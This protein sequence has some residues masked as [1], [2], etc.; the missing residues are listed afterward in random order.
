[1]HTATGAVKSNRNN[2]SISKDISNPFPQ[3]DCLRIDLQVYDA[4]VGASNGLI[5]AMPD[6]FLPGHKLIQLLKNRGCTA[7]TVTNK[8]NIA[9]CEELKA[10][11][12]DILAGAEFDC[13]EPQTGADVTVLAYGFSAGQLKE[14]V[15][16]KA[17]VFAFAK[18]AFVENIPLVWA[19]PNPSDADF[20]KLCLIFQNILVLSD[21][22]NESLCAEVNAA[23]KELTPTKLKTLAKQ[24]G[25]NP[26]DY[27]KAPWTRGLVGGSGSANGLFAGRTG[28]LLYVPRL[29]ERLKETSA[30]SLAVEALL[31]GNGA[32]FGSAGSQGKAL[33]DGLIKATEQALHIRDEY[34]PEIFLQN[35]SAG[36]K[37]FSL[38]AAN[39]LI[40]AKQ[41]PFVKAGLKFFLA[42]VK[43][44]SPSLLFK[45]AP[46]PAAYKGIWSNLGQINSLMKKQAEPDIVCKHIDAIYAETLQL[47]A[48]EAAAGLNKIDGAAAWHIIASGD[49]SAASVEQTAGAASADMS[50][51]AKK[52]AA[53]AAGTAVLN[54]AYFLA[55]RKM[56]LQSPPRQKRMLWLTDTLE[57]GNG[58]AMFLQSMLTEIRRRNLPIDIMVCSNKLRSGS[59]LKV[60]KPEAGFT[61]PFYPQQPFRIPSYVKIQQ[62]FEQ[63]GYDRIIASTEGPMG[64]A[65]LYLKHAFRVPAHFYMHTDW[66]AFG[67][68]ML[69]FSKQKLTRWEAWL[70]DIYKAFDK[71]FV[72]NSD[73]KKWLTGERM[74]FAP[75]NVYQSAHWADDVF[76]PVKASKQKLFGVDG[77]TPLLLFV[78]RLSEE[79]GIYDLPDIL[80][81]VKKRVPNAVLAIA[82]AGPEDAKIKAALP[83]AIFL[84]WT[85][86]E[87]LPAYYSSADILLLPSRFD[88]FGVVV[89]EALSCGCPVAAYNMKGPKDILT[90]GKNGFLANTKA[91][92]A[93]DITGYLLAK[94]LH[95]KIKKAAIDRAKEYTAEII[96]DKLIKDVNL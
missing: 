20:H 80:A 14:L 24:Y 62:L 34:I 15:R 17:D 78:G 64:I 45:L 5:A 69:K 61:L 55:A 27:C 53:P 11:G 6:S 82:G 18:Y 10:A 12:I 94:S 90:H 67:R 42:S 41:K 19:N 91:G 92:M 2:K 87:K 29:S 56:S 44:Q 23:V 25:I 74:E 40:K 39:L 54:A 71:L 95:N 70:I 31:A 50:K 38:A 52:I 65:A 46:T 47:L 73:Q 72:L 30:S 37:I 83:D 21:V 16:L 49:S 26:E 93:K 81:D 76:K 59:H 75:A 60:V 77:N 66:K 9:S 28:S 7:F 48:K 58:I 79:K 84:G 68:D 89:L 4:N 3:T 85:Q 13:K 8:E 51:L 88:T 1:M 33:I 22:R 57:D 43:G 36:K 35:A 96:T 63:G 32:P 86:H